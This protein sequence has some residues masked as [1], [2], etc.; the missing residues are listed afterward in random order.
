MATTRTINNAKRNLICPSSS[1]SFSSKK[2]GTT[3]TNCQN[4]RLV[5]PLLGVVVVF[6]VAGQIWFGIISSSSTS[7]SSYCDDLWTHEQGPQQQKYNREPNVSSKQQQQPLLLLPP[8]HVNSSWIGNQWMPP[9]GYR[10][11]TTREIQHYFYNEQHSI[12]IVGDS[13]ARRFYGTLYGIFNATSNPYNVHVHEINSPNVIDV[14]KGRRSKNKNNQKQRQEQQDCSQI[15]GHGYDLCRYM[16]DDSTSKSHSKQQQQQ[17]RPYDL[18]RAT[19]LSSIEELLQDPDGILWKQSSTLSTNG[20]D[21]INHGNNASSSSLSPCYS[22]VIFIIGPWEVMDTMDCSSGLLGRKNQTDRIMNMLFEL[23][24]TT[25]IEFIWRTWGCPGTT[26]SNR[27]NPQYTI[28]LWNHAQSHNTYVKYLIDNFN[29]EGGGIVGTNRMSKSGGGGGVSY[30]DFGQAVAPRL[31]PNEVRIAGDIDP[32]YGL[33]IRVAFV[34]MLM[35]HLKERTKQKQFATTTTIVSSKNEEEEEKNR[36]KFQISDTNIIATILKGNHPFMTIVQ[37]E[38][39]LFPSSSHEQ[40]MIDEARI[41]FCGDCMYNNQTTCQS[42]V[43]QY[44]FHKNIPESQS[45]LKVIQRHQSCDKR[46]NPE[47]QISNFPP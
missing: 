42:Q 7:S 18:Y 15:K 17:R 6:V 19:C 32:H 22:L 31:F 47:F 27:N 14:N 46:R 38:V 1:S 44:R 9:P 11:Y 16:P 25:N 4:I 10:L 36:N 2:R 20:N 29:N 26:H 45:I 37:P 39:Q 41:K 5:V 13:T 40:R 8:I 43:N 30:I 35:N 3:N 34:Q 21:T 24:K 12:L 23:S 28:E 33:E